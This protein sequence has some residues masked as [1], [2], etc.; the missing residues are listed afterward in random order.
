MG[1]EKARHKAGQVSRS[2]RVA[3]IQSTYQ[4]SAFFKL[5]PRRLSAFLGV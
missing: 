3:E 1:K 4:T 2:K 5:L